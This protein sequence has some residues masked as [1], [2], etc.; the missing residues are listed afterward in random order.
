MTTH[1]SGVSPHTGVLWYIQL[2]APAR[3][4]ELG[5]R[6]L[7]TGRHQGCYPEAPCHV[8]RPILPDASCGEP[9][10]HTECTP[11]QHSTASTALA[12]MEECGFPHG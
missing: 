1:P 2:I 8:R 5:G 6:L 11:P 4:T 3:S 7:L 9:R 10:V 12:V